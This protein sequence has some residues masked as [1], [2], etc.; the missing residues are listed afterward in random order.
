MQRILFFLLILFSVSSAK[1]QL[2]QI[3]GFEGDIY[4]NPGL[5]GTD[6]FTV[7]RYSWYYSTWF[8]LPRTGFNPEDQI[9]AIAVA[10]TGDSYV[11]GLYALADTA[12]YLFSW[13][14][15]EWF[16]LY[17]TG[18]NRESDIPQISDISITGGG[19]SSSDHTVY[20]LS[21]GQLFEYVW[22]GDYW[23]PREG[24]T[25]R[26]DKANSSKAAAGLYPNPTSDKTRIDIEL[27]EAYTGD[28][29]ISLFNTSGKLLKES[30]F[31]ILSQKQIQ[32]DISTAEFGQGMYFC[33][34]IIADK[35]ILK[36]L[37]VQ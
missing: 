33:E 26:T 27:P 16:Y 34:I 25:D 31:K 10:D 23:Y 19:T 17:N 11:S 37:L 36:T 6:G 32:F 2:T 22:Y 4:T 29:F 1:A 20:A 9:K 8:E 15:D 12:V 13:Y 24:L 30:H 14:Y 18:L 21:G 28:I 35:R 5:F 7:Y 3:A